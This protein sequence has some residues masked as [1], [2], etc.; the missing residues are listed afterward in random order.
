[1]QLDVGSEDRA[2]REGGVVRCGAAP[3][4]AVAPA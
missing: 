3:E 1:M 2:E 4:T